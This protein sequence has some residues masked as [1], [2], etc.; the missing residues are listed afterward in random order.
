MPDISLCKN[1]Q[2]PSKTKCFRYMAEPKQYKQSYA[3]FTLDMNDKC[4]SYID[5][6]KYPHFKMRSKHENIHSNSKRNIHR[7]A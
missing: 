6:S 7:Y 4:S 5:A 1:N 2:C 3:Y